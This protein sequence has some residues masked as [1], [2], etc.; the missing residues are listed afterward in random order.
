[1]RILFFLVALLVYVPVAFATTT[2]EY[3]VLTLI[4]IEREERGLE[5]LT[6]DEKLS[7]AAYEHA[8]DMSDHNYLAHT[9]P[10]GSTMGSRLRDA[11]A[12][13]TTAGENIAR[14]YKTALSVVSGWMNSRG[15]R[16]NILNRRYRK[17]GIARVNNYWVQDFSN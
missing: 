11:G 12:R 6:M 7:A 1:M 14:G 16:A 15:H 2:S 4:N 8:S 13:F 3:R 9:S 17:V 5:R 10:N